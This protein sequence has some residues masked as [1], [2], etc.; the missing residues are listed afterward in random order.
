MTGRGL[1]C[2]RSRLRRYNQVCD[3]VRPTYGAATR[4]LSPRLLIAPPVA[5]IW[6]VVVERELA[7][8]AL[9]GLKLSDWRKLSD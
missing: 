3:F 8:M 4:P 7:S 2:R 1:L 5:P 9:A 6:A